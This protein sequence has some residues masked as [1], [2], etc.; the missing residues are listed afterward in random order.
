MKIGP[1]TITVGAPPV[2]RAAEA[3][4]AA[5]AAEWLAIF[6][7]NLRTVPEEQRARLRRVVEILRE[8]AKVD[9]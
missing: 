4:T 5:D 1:L 9:V 3:W 7:E 8:R 2:S 6:A